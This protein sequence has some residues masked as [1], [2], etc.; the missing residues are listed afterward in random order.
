[1]YPML[2]NRADQLWTDTVS[3]ATNKVHEVVDQGISAVS[4]VVRSTTAT[5]QQESSKALEQAQVGVGK[6]RGRQE[7]RVHLP[8]TLCRGLVPVL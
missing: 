3:K 8:S 7:G 6:Q 1:M 2:C 5:V 4:S